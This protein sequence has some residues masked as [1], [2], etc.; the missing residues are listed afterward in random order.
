[1]S[2]MNTPP[3][4]QA[5]G[6]TKVVIAALVLALIAVIATNVYIDQVRRTVK[7][8]SFAVYIFEY[9]VN[10][11][12]KFK[13][14]S[15]RE[16]SVPINYESNFRK[17]KCID[18]NQL[19]SGNYDNK[20]LQRGAVSGQFLTSDLFELRNEDRPDL[21]M[22]DGMRL[23]ALAVA[24]RPQLT[25]LQPE[26][27]VDIMVPLNTGT[28][29]NQMMLVMENVRVLAVGTRMATD[30]SSGR[31]VAGSY[32][33]ITVQVKPEEAL[34]LS[35]IEKAAAGPFELQIRK[36][37]DRKPIVITK[38]G[39]NEEVLNIVRARRI[40]RPGGGTGN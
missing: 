18:K 5:V 26:M 31:A 37:S 2:Q 1:M 36:P 13:A 3:T 22:D 30:E 9:D 33:S 39:I 4:M 32:Q 19:T 21:R 8:S 17:L 29:Y 35:T 27:H 12:E 6:G 16:V 7:Q 38:G 34:E 25:I 40:I 28:R 20:E 11:G 23:I 14:D 15:V 10:R 24:S